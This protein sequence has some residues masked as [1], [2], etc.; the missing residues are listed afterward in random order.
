[1]NT[2]T[3]EDT[4]TVRMFDV[5]V[6]QRVVRHLHV[7]TFSEDAQHAREKVESMLQSCSNDFDTFLVYLQGLGREDP[8]TYT[9]TVRVETVRGEYDAQPFS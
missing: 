9:K 3:T 7:P 4:P 8:Q 5:V 1:M 6:V 2:R